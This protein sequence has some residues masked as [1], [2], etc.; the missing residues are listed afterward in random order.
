[1]CVYT[2]A[3]VPFLECGDGECDRGIVLSL[4]Y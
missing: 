3:T 4:R 1:M 2:Q